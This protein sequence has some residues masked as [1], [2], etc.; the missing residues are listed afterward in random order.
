MKNK[1]LTNEDVEKLHSCIIDSGPVLGKV[2]ISEAQRKVLES[3]QL[4]EEVK[5]D[6]KEY[7]AKEKIEQ[8][9]KA[10]EIPVSPSIP[11]ADVERLYHALTG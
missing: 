3:K 2:E 6:L 9:I 4:I 11:G 10:L 1:P 7:R 5:K 8:L